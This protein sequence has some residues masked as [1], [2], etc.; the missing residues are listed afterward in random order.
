MPEGSTYAVLL[1]EAEYRNFR[2]AVAERDDLTHVWFVTNSEEH[3]A[4][5]RGRLPG[6]RKTGML[7]RDYLRNFRI[8]DGVGSRA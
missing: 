6:K 5:M 4:E 2:A 7:V 1:E 3:F 8:Y